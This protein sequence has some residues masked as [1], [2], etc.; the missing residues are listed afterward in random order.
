MEFKLLI[1]FTP[2][3]TQLITNLVDTLTGG[4]PSKQQAPV[5]Q[6]TT[7]QEPK[8]ETNTAAS[9]F[10]EDAGETVSLEDVRK[11]ATAKKEAGKSTHVKSALET[12]G[13]KTLPE[14]PK[15]RRGE[16]LDL[17]KQAS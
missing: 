8:Q 17:L 4:A 10:T 16:F 14:I 7:K 11:A 2:E 15:E 3:A 12:I 1:G 5:K 9:E 13:V 6:M